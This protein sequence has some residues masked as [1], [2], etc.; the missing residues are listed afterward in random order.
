MHE[1]LHFADET[2]L[3]C[4]EATSVHIQFRHHLLLGEVILFHLELFLL[5]VIDTSLK[6]MSKRLKSFEG[7]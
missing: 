3:E 1:F 4:V 7:C 2:A 6:K 5:S